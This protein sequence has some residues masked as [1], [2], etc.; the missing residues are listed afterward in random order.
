[1]EQHLKN[2]KNRCRVCGRKL[3]SYMHSKQSTI[4]EALLSTMLKIEPKSESE[5]IFPPVVCNSCYITL[6]KANDDGSD[7]ALT[8]INIHTWK[9]HSDSCQL[10]LDSPSGGRP[11]RKRKGRPCDDDPTFQH[12]KILRRLEELTSD[13][14]ADLPLQ[15]SLFLS[16]PHL[17]NLACHHCKCISPLPVELTSC[18]HLLCRKCIRDEHITTCPCNSET[19]IQVDHLNKP[20]P[21]VLNLIN[22]QLVHCS[23]NCGEVM[24]LK[25]LTAHLSSNCESTTVPSPSKLTVRQLLDLNKED[26]PSLMEIQAM[27]VVTKG[28]VPTSGHV[29]CRSSSGKVTMHII[30]TQS[31]NCMCGILF[32]R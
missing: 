22:S 5:E 30:I 24:E 21:I 2:L 12:R 20:S 16:S 13:N 25:H 14:T 15:R 27:G 4:C 32:S 26:K 1:M 28:L 8:N 19:T 7:I 17:D 29:T 3:T 11:K 6:K 10:C 18:R 23:S 31:N 9:P